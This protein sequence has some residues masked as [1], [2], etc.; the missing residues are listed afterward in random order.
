MENEE[1][2]VS[3]CVYSY[4]DTGAAAEKISEG[5]TETHEDYRLRDMVR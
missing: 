4:P 2:S 3:S 1:E 5:D